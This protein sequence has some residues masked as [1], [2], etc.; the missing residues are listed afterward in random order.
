MLH[1]ECQFELED[2]GELDTLITV[3]RELFGLNSSL[4]VLSSL[5]WIH[6]FYILETLHFCCVFLAQFK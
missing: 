5:T 3:N 6:L 1:A 4:N 2:L